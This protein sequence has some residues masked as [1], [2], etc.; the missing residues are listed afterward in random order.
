MHALKMNSKTFH[1][2]SVVPEFIVVEMSERGSF[3]SRPC[4]GEE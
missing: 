4:K 1:K 2:T 3:E